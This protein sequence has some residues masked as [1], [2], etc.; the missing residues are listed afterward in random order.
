MSDAIPPALTPEE[1][2][3]PPDPAWPHHALTSTTYALRP[4]LT[5]SLW[6]D[7]DLLVEGKDDT[8]ISVVE[9]A[10]HALAALALHG[11]P[12]GFTHA[13]V[14]NLRMAAE[15]VGSTRASALLLDLA[16]RLA[17]LLPP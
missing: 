12:F 1:W 7:G 17:A 3:T 4:G 10:R 14:G 9:S 15:L 6:S 2:A 16:E 11:Q 5:V 8:S 13:D